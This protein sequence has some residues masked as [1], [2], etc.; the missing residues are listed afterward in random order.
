[1]FQV[2]KTVDNTT[3]CAANKAELI[4]L[5]KQRSRIIMGST[6][7]YIEVYLDD[8]TL[9]NGFYASDF[10]YSV[11]EKN[12]EYK[13]IQI[14][15]TLNQFIHRF[16]ILDTPSPFLNIIQVTPGLTDRVPVHD[17]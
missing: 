10:K 16:E 8:I 4:S 1:M 7:A 14:K 6:K 2:I 9:Q 12:Y 3:G 11:L 15:D 5:Y 17:M 13:T